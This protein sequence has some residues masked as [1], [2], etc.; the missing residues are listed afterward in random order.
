MRYYDFSHH[1]RMKAET[2]SGCK[3]RTAGNMYNFALSAAS[4]VPQRLIKPWSTNRR[5]ISMARST[6][7]CPRRMSK[8]NSPRYCSDSIW[9]SSTSSPAITARKLPP[10]SRPAAPSSSASHPTGSTAFVSKWPSSN[11]RP[12]AESQ[13][14]D[15]QSPVKRRRGN[16]RTLGSGP[17]KGIPKA[18]SISF[19]GCIGRCCNG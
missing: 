14:A 13:G 9:S 1:L 10:F 8:P 2:A 19:T 7:T 5:P 12:C 4:G 6:G 16:L 3:P 15:H 11:S 18:A 17:I